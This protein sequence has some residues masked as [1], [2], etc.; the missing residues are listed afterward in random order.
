MQNLSTLIII[1]AVHIWDV[2]I[3]CNSF[4]CRSGIHVSCNDRGVYKLQ[5]NVAIFSGNINSQP[6]DNPTP[7]SEPCSSSSA[8]PASPG[9]IRSEARPTTPAPDVTPRRAPLEVPG[10]SSRKRKADDV[11]EWLQKM[12]KEDREE[13]ASLR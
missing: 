6:T 10:S 7:M 13:T 3:S 11:P 4:I 2:A 1:E 9:T 12:M 8:S 5:I